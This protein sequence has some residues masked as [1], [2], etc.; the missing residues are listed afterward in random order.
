MSE[1]GL[2]HYAMAR[3][4]PAPDFR[5]AL[6]RHAR[7]AALLA[8]S[9]LLHAAVIGWA[10]GRLA[11][12]VQNTPLPEAITVSLLAPPPPPPPKPRP[13]LKPKPKPVPKPA[14]SPS[15]AQPA[16]APAPVAAVAPDEVATRA[17][18]APPPDDTPSL[19]ELMPALD[20][21]PAS[22]RLLWQAVDLPPSAELRYDVIAVKNEQKWYGNGA[23]RWEA[24]GDRYRLSG[25]ANATLLFFNL[26]A[27][28]FASEG[29]INEFG[30]AP[31]HY[32]EKPRNK[33]E[34]VAVFRHDAQRIDFAATNGSHPYH[35]GEQ[36]RASVIWQLA[37]IGRAAPERIA[38]GTELDLVVAGPRDADVWHIRVLGLEQVESNDGPVP[39]WHL[40]RV[41]Q[42]DAGARRIDIWL[43]PELGWYPVRIRQSDADGDYLELTLDALHPLTAQ[44]EPME[45]P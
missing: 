1:A 17:V 4:R 29:V 6:A 42:R 34:M 44:T 38:A 15:P 21:E 27:L 37:G 2:L 3:T 12:P 45:R 9:L 5:S 7:W 40:A 41:R 16:S 25:E 35:G 22:P 14:A 20:F 36:D 39:A 31:L 18:S 19:A 24:D 33:P 8:A 43:A 32:S 28:N 26:T 30:V 23:F 10:G 13:R 11:F